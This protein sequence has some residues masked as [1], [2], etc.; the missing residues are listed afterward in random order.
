MKKWI[1]NNLILVWA[2]A[3]VIYAFIIHVLFSLYPSNDW[4]IAKWTAGEILTYASTVSL[5]LLAVWQNRKIQSEN[6]KAQERLERIIEQSNQLEII[7]KIVEYETSNF[8]RLRTAFDVFSEA[9]NPQRIVS[10]MGKSEFKTYMLKTEMVLA[11]SEIDRA[12]FV[13]GR[14]LRIDKAIKEDDKNTLKKNYK[15]YYLGAKGLV[16]YI[17]DHTEAN[18]FGEKVIELLKLRDA[19]LDEREKYMV[20]QEEKL[21]KLLYENLTK[22]QIKELYNR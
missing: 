18:D 4:L 19:F 6:D 22:E 8:S 21:N 14:E 9:C 3:S 11:E 12:F 1:N 16:V 7:G 2:V 5:G 13:L 10:L 20:H 17:R 15:N